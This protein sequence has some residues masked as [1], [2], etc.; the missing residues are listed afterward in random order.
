MQPLLNFCK[1]LDLE[2]NPSLRDFRRRRGGV[3]L[4]ERNL[5]GEVSIEPIRGPYLK[6]AQEDWLRTPLKVEK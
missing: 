3:Q 5:E 4:Y 1:E 2:E 6:E